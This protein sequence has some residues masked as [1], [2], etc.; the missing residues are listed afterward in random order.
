[1]LKLLESPRVP[2]DIVAPIKK[3]RVKTKTVAEDTKVTYKLIKQGNTGN[4]EALFNLY[5][6]DRFKA[7]VKYFSDPNKFKY[8]RVVIFELGEKDF[9]ITEFE[10]KFGISV[11]NRIYSSQKKL[12]SVTFKKGKF[13][14]VDKL[15]GRLLPL[16]LASFIRFIREVEIGHS[17]EKETHAY[18]ISKSQIYQYMYSKFPW[19]QMLLDTDAAHGIAFNTVYSKKL[20]GQ[21]D[22]LRHILKIP[23]N[24]INI[25]MEVPVPIEMINNRF[26]HRASNRPRDAYSSLKRWKEV[27]SLLDGVQNLTADLYHHPHFYDTCMM[28]KQL[29][30]KVNC[31]WG[32]KKLEQVHDDWSRDIR[33]ILLD[34][35][36][37]YRLKLHQVYFGLAN[38]TKWK[39]LFTNK[40]MLVEGMRQNHCVGGYIDRVQRGE[41]AIFHV[42]GYTLQ[43][44]VDKV[45]KKPL[46]VRVINPCAEIQLNDDEVDNLFGNE[47]QVEMVNDEYNGWQVMKYVEKEVPKEKE[48]YVTA[49]KNIQFRGHKNCNP[50][51]ELVDRV[52]ALLEEYSNTKEFIDLFERKATLTDEVYNE[53][54]KTRW[55]V[56]INHETG[57][58]MIKEDVENPSVTIDKLVANADMPLFR[59]DDEHLP[60]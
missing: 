5:K 28:A 38:F 47:V 31:R 50:P 13:Y 17:Y 16:T 32:I 41:C 59:V 34:C 24:I 53:I 18:L 39:L 48:E 56:V 58:Y 52:N 6:E 2:K 8:D 12:R 46:E 7:R 25:V 42:D 14:H 30:K 33:N 9:E 49:F 1:M 19:I 3:K 23:M 40:E 4:V 55:E 57:K 15:R 10:N 43:V 20:F 11:T 22:V 54:Y 51:Q 35:E 27:S 37:E 21:K 60:F 29:G 45:K 44:T 26:Y 36:L